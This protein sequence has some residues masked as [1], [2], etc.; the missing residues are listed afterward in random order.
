MAKKKR[1]EREMSEELLSAFK[2]GIKQN[3]STLEEM[4][5]MAF[6][7]LSEDEKDNF[8][9]LLNLA[10]R[11]ITPEEYAQFYH[12]FQLSSSLAEGICGDEDSGL[13]PFMPTIFKGERHDI[14]E[15]APLKN[16]SEC[17]L[18]LKIQMKDVSKPPMWRELEIPA[19]YNFLQLHEA[20][21]AV[22]G[23]EDCH[24]WQFN[25][26]AY[27]DSLLIGST[28]N[29]RFSR[30]VDCITHEAEETLLTQFLQQKGDKLEYVYDFGDDWIFIVEMKNLCDKK[31]EHP[32]CRRYKGELNAIEDF[33]GVWSYLEA[34]EDLE[35]W[36]SMTKK[37]K[38]KRYEDRGFDSEDEY[39]EFLS[40]NRLSLDDVNNELELI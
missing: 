5:E 28:P 4:S 21:Q 40:E 35:S 30:G 23:L 17:T 38:R 15:Y 9:T 36:G 27:D 10:C 19:D 39:L 13:S 14:K 33:G 11:G 31:I 20:I 7:S 32:I 34:R 3:S 26:K 6:E 25:I 37:E 18:V 22:V 1:G 12:I 2:G 24:L 16:A 29:D 8:G